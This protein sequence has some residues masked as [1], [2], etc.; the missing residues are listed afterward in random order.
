[1]INSYKDILQAIDR[2]NPNGPRFEL[3]ATEEQSA[4]E[5]I[6]H[7]AD[8]LRSG[9]CPENL[10]LDL[11][12]RKDRAIHRY[13]EIE[14]EEER[15]C[16][17]RN[18]PFIVVREPF[19]G[20]LELHYERSPGKYAPYRYHQCRPLVEL[21]DQDMQRITEALQLGPLVVTLEI[22]S[23]SRAVVLQSGA[24]PNKPITD[25]PRWTPLMLAIFRHNIETAIRMVESPEFVYTPHRGG[26]ALMIASSSGYQ[27]ECKD[28]IRLLT[29]KKKEYENALKGQH[30]TDTVSTNNDVVDTNAN[31][32]SSNVSNGILMLSAPAKDALNRIPGISS[33]TFN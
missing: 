5:I 23:G 4:R 9:G 11:T 10:Y 19:T 22:Q 21:T 15:R 20:R 14:A 31:Q 8:A 30:N 26:S 1:M 13:N 6:M 18:A 29:S 24:V 3:N 33:M 7:L 27:A 17:W 25:N 16:N 28:L 12:Q 32:Q 2:G